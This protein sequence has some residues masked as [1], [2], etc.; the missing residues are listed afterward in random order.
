MSHEISNQFLRSLWVHYQ[1]CRSLRE[2]RPPLPV[3]LLEKHATFLSEA[4]KVYPFAKTSTSY[5]YSKRSISS[6]PATLSG[7]LFRISRTAWQINRPR[8]GMLASSIN[9]TAPAYDSAN[10]GLSSCNHV[11]ILSFII[12]SQILL[13]QFLNNQYINHRKQVKQYFF[14]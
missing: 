9:L 11:N 3:C 14:L 6:F 8:P 4:S 7:S 13:L 2:N 5:L 12:L 1:R 10:S